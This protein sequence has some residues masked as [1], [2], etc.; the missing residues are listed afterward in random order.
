MSY[1][2]IPNLS[3]SVVTGVVP[4]EFHRELPKEVAFD[5]AKFV[6]WCQ[7]PD[8][9]NCHYT[10]YEGMDPHLRLTKV[11]GPYRM[12]AVIV[13]FDSKI[14]DGDVA[15]IKKR[16]KSEFF[17]NWGSKT[18][19][20][21]MRLVWEFES[22]VMLPESKDVVR[23]FLAKIKKNLKPDKLLPGFDEEAFF[24]VHKYY[25][26]GLEWQA[27]SSDKIPFNLLCLWMMEAGENANFTKD[28]VS[29]PLGEIEKEAGIRFP[30]KWQ[31]PFEEG[32][33][34]CRFW[35]SGADNHT[36]AVIRAEGM[37]CFTGSQAFVTWREIFGPGFCQKFESTRIGEVGLTTFYDGVKY[38]RQDEPEHWTPLNK[39]D[40]KLHLKVRH[41][42]S[43]TAGRKETSS[44]VERTMHFIQ[45]HNRIEA[46]VPSIH[47]TPGIIRVDGKRFLNISQIKVVEPAENKNLRWG[48]N[49]PWMANFL[50]NFFDPADS[51]EFFLAWLKWYY[52][53]ALV[54]RPRSGQAVFIAGNAGTGKTLLSTAIIA[55]MVGGHQDAS[56]FL[57]EGEDFND[58]ILEAPL[59]T[60]DDCVA[61]ATKAGQSRYSATIKRLIANRHF[62][63]KKKFEKSGQV[64]WQGRIMVTM[65]LDPESLRLLP[66]VEMSNLDKV[67][68]FR[69]KDGYRDFSGDLS[70]TVA[71]EL[72]YFCKWLCEWEVPAQCAGDDRFGVEAYHEPSLYQLAAHAESSYSFLEIIDEFRRRVWEFNRNDPKW[73]GQWEGTTTQLMSILL[74][75]PD[76]EP[77]ARAY[78]NPQHVGRE[79][80]KL[81]AWENPVVFPS[82]TITTLRVWCIDC[83]PRKEDIAAWTGR[84]ARAKA[85]QNLVP[86][87]E[88]VARLGVENPLSPTEP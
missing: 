76:L 30:N 55:P 83:N 64:S 8:T 19:S 77:I 6:E 70:A 7:K 22:P 71:R 63:Y 14:S 44:E 54:R 86:S 80:G 85:L 74:S 78:A 38:W 34:G 40:F 56:E 26:I 18:F 36:A 52:C 43:A 39:D 65:N 35:D 27:M 50:D 73:T 12:H 53:N 25:D 68:F 84:M 62:V 28:K 72:P 67:S 69:V 11:N 2:A 66:S 9:Q 20:S 16:S 46:A 23:A 60:L 3:S 10:A 49:F 24:D 37:Q 82:K 5:K 15:A 75:T 51:K 58:Y 81:S 13:D 48:E 47:N 87:T 29:I 4:W 45:E 61:T 79:L 21:G 33:R 57:V 42:M 1:Y 32:R 17:P 41:G 59:L 31:G 88:S